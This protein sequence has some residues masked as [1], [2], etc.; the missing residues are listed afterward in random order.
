LR[1]LSHLL[2]NFPD[3]FEGSPRPVVIHSKQPG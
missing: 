1:S 3:Y 2:R